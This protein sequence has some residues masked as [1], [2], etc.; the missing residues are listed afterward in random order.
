M[1]K[2]LIWLT[3]LFLIGLLVGCGPAQTVPEEGVNEFYQTLKDEEYTLW[4]K[5]PGYEVRQPGTGFHL[6]KVDIYINDVMVTA[7]SNNSNKK[8]R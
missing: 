1:K 5:A 2:V 7:L 3:L 8:H 6:S 4:D